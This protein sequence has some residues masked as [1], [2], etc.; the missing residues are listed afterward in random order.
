MLHATRRG[1]AT[2]DEGVATPWAPLIMIMQYFLG[3]SGP[4]AEAGT[5]GGG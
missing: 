3:G 4:G 2:L 5:G 1:H